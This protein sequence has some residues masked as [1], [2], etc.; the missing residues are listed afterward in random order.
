MSGIRM[1][2][3]THP[4]AGSGMVFRKALAEALART[5]RPAV[6]SRNTSESRIASSSSMTCT[7]RSVMV[8][9]V[10]GPHGAEGEPEGR[11]AP[12]VGLHP[13]PPAMG[14]DNRPRN[15]QTHAHALGFGGEEGFE[16]PLDDIGANA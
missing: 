12:V 13:Y 14:L 8:T 2:V 3:T 7:R 10:L 4:S 1:S 16:Q 6:S 5:R 15:R 11:P 9:Q